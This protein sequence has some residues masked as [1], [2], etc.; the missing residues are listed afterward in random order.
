MKEFNLEEYS[1]LCADFMGMKHVDFDWNWIMEVFEK[2]EESLGGLVVIEGN[3][4]FI[5]VTVKYRNYNN[6][7]VEPQSK[8]EAAIHAIW[9]FLNWY[10]ENEQYIK[11]NK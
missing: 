11:E 5:C 3:T 4:F 2:I 1:E 10:K 8:K 6:T 7:T 9:Q